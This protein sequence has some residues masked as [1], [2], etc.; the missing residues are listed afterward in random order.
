[1]GRLQSGV[2]PGLGMEMA[3]VIL[4]DDLSQE[5]DGCHILLVAHGIFWN[6]VLGGGSFPVLYAA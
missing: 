1:M 5:L 2:Q 6:A 4:V 3:L